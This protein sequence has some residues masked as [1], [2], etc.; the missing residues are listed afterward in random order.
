VG[1]AASTTGCSQAEVGKLTN[2]NYTADYYFF[3]TK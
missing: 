3:T 1:G 2:S